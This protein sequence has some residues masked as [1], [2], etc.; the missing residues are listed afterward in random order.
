MVKSKEQANAGQLSED[1]SDDRLANRQ[2]KGQI[3]SVQFE[4]QVRSNETIEEACYPRE[5]PAAFSI[6]LT[7]P[8]QAQLGQF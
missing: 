8:I 3:T 4:R 5:L 7:D 1:E 6:A 2:E